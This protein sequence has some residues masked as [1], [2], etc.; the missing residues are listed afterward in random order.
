LSYR[1]LLYFVGKRIQYIKMISYNSKN[2]SLGITLIFLCLS[3]SIF[4]QNN[5]ELTKEISGQITHLNAPLPNVN[6]IILDSKKGTKT[7]TQGNY[8]INAKVGDIIQYSYVGFN[9]VSIIVEDITSVLN[10]EMTQKVNKLEETVVNARKKIGRVSEIAAKKNAKFKTAVGVFN[11]KASGFSIPYISGDEV[12]IG[13]PSLTAT[14][15]GKRAGVT[16][17]FLE[18]AIWDVDGQIFNEEPPIDLSNI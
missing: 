9:T 7:D 17:G 12:N 11:P 6:I 16:K 8:S 18:S 5:S 10:I 4:A 15:R 3:L 2:T 1:Y 13:A 14:L